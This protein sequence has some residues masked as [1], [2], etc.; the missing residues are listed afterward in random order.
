MEGTKLS[1][2]VLRV[3]DCHI[4][5]PGASSLLGLLL[6]NGPLLVTEDGSLRSNNASW[7]NLVDYV[8][9]DQPVY[10]WRLLI[11]AQGSCV[12]MMREQRH[13]LFDSRS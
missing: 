6:E 2:F 5:R 11:L 3:T 7:A 10:V 12:R 13:R 8:W 1:N 4:I 9:V